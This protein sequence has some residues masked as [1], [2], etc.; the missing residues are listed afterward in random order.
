MVYGL[1]IVDKSTL[2]KEGLSILLKDMPSFELLL[3]ADNTLQLLN[4]LS[5]LKELPK[6]IFIDYDEEQFHI[7]NFHLIKN[8]FPSI[9]YIA[10]Y[11]QCND[12]S[13]IDL[14]ANGFLGC[15]HKTELIQSTLNLMIKK[16]YIQNKFLFVKPILKL[17]MN[18]R[19]DEY[20]WFLNSIKS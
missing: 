4:T 1:G 14:K 19:N 3:Q 13:E 9:Y 2:F 15:I 7:S 17:N 12:I 16:T 10:T 18:Y 5:A 20:M 6:F 8:K 11:L